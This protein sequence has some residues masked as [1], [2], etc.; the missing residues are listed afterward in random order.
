MV[1]W[2][3]GWQGEM[4]GRDYRGAPGL[5]GMDMFAILIVVMVWQVYTYVKA[6][7]IVHFKYLVY[8]MSIILQ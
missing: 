6:Y 3:G 4:E 1:T 2:V 8:F 5:K 7:K